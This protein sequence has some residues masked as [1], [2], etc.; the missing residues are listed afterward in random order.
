[1]YETLSVPGAGR[2][3]FQLATANLNPKSE[4]AV[5]TR[6][7]ERGPLLII[8]G[9]M[10]RI[11]PTAVA[12]GA[13]KRQ[14]RNPGITEFVELKGLGHSLVFDEGSSTVADAT[15]DFLRRTVG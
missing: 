5:D 14:R 15:L 6:S 13:F 3:M 12:H 2:P 10:D 11:V 8:S 1:L 7:P 4:C 9:E